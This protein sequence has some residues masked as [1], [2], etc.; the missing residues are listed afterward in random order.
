VIVAAGRSPKT[1]KAKGEAEFKNRGVTYC[2]TCDGPLFAGKDV[3]VVGGGNSALDA[4]MQ[5][6]PIAAR[7]YMIDIADHIIGDPVMLEKVKS[8]PKVEILSKTEVKEITGDKF[9]N[10]VKV[11]VRKSEE[12]TIPVEGV[13]IEIGSMPSKDPACSVK[14]NE[15]GEMIVNER[16]ETSVPGLFAAGDITSV[17][18]KQIIVA[19]GQGCVACLSAFRYLSRKKIKEG[20]ENG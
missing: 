10:A 3:A 20:E 14:L 8:S 5:L 2:A 18:E 16:C 15:K 12:R 4:A 19:A 1:L 7:I 13:F 11:V 9:V 6:M 17:P